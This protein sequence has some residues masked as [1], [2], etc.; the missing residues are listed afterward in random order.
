MRRTII[1]RFEIIRINVYIVITKIIEEFSVS[2][3][4]LVRKKRAEK[5]NLCKLKVM[6]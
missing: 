3:D 4:I 5:K 2:M 1:D 6:A